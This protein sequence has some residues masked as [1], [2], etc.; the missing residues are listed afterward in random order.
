V[1][2]VLSFNENT[3]LSRGNLIHNVWGKYANIKSRSL[4]QYI[5][6]VRQLLK[7]NASDLNALRTLHGIG[8]I[9]TTKPDIPDM[10]RRE[11]ADAFEVML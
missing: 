7:A 3:I 10:T 4:D 5:V 8:H 9:Y 2:F 1:A 6:K 11:C